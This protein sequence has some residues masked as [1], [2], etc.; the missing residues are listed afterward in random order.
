MTRHLLASLLLVATACATT[1]QKQPSASPSG[2]TASTTTTLDV[3]WTPLAFL[4]GE[5]G[6]APGATPGESRGWFSLQPELGGKVLVRRNVNESPRGR[7]EDLMTF[8]REGENLRAFYVDNEDHV[9]HYTVVPGDRSVT[10]TS[11]EVPGRPR[12]RLTYQQKEDAKLDIVFAIQPPGATEFK[13][14]LQ[15]T[16]VRR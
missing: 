16:V 13:T 8:Y 12:F 5:W 2:P 10:L 11:D 15:G 6:D 1:G 7:H 14:Y 3:A 9:I 4:V